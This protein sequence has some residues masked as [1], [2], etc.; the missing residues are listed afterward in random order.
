MSK[1]NVPIFDREREKSPPLGSG[2]I[3]WGEV[4]KRGDADYL[5]GNCLGNWPYMPLFSV[6]NKME[7]I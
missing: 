6:A 7:Q 4:E 2:K 3:F 1:S 5:C